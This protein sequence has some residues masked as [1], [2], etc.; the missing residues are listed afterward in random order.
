ML[1]WYAVHIRSRH[2]FV[3]QAELSRKNI[4]TF[5][6]TFRSLRRWKDRDKWINFPLFPGYFFVKIVP[7]PN[8]FQRVHRTRGVVN[9]VSS[10]AIHPTPVSYEEINSL[11]L[12]IESGIDFDVCPRLL[13][14]TKVIIR[15]GPL[16]GAEGIITRKLDRYMLQVNIKILG[17]SVGVDIHGD[18]VEVA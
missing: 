12:I 11:K 15:K 1:N 4:E 8:E 3:T 7:S 18:Y 6:P 13:E 10:E 14:G 2:E 5:L 17:R 9:I 16:R